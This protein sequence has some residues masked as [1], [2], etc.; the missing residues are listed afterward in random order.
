MVGWYDTLSVVEIAY[1]RCLGLEAKFSLW[2]PGDRKPQFEPRHYQLPSL[3]A[4]SIQDEDPAST[5]S[6]P[7]SIEV[8]F[9]VNKHSL[10]FQGVCLSE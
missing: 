10:F 9:T 4:D 3:Q 5:I 7:T 6:Q 2:L 8:S 1:S